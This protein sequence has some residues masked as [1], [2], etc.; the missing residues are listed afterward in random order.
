MLRASCGPIRALLFSAAL[1][2]SC[3]PRHDDVELNTWTVVAV[4][5][6]TGATGIAG[7][8]CVPRSVDAIAL[9]APGKGAAVVQGLWSLDN[10]N[11]VFEFLNSG[12]TAEEIVRK[13]RALTDSSAERRQYAAVTLRE[14]KTQVAAFTGADTLPWSGSRQDNA[15]AVSVQGNV[16][17]RESVVADA[18]TAF[19]ASD[20]AGQNTIP[21]RLMR[22]LEAGSKAG[23]D[24]RC[25]ASAVKQT[26]L[27][28]FIVY[29]R[30][31]E[32]AYTARDLGVTDAGNPGAPSLALSVT[33]LPNGDNPVFE[34]RKQYD[35]WRSGKK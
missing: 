34:L 28:A 7:A 6:A 15:L 30:A 5:P 1:L 27:S 16:L 23:G 12:E 14:K 22:A 3:A 20:A 24:K 4:D 26:A 2:S 32:A 35:G 25:N 17:E 18:L 29:A 8:S 13:A 10:R 21:D 33:M 9:L 19:K 11:R 31:G